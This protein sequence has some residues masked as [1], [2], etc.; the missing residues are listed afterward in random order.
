M[1]GKLKV[2]NKLM[3]WGIICAAP[4]N[5]RTVVSVQKL[6][7][8]IENGKLEDF[9]SQEKKLRDFFCVEKNI[10]KNKC[11]YFFVYIWKSPEKN[12]DPDDLYAPFSDSAMQDWVA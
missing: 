2:G 6:K 10:H 1:V 12:Y 5:K 11:V 8:S 7:P 4:V 3:T 9:E